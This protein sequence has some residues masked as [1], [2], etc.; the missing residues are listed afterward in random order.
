M[1]RREASVVVRLVL[2]DAIVATVVAPVTPSFPGKV[3]AE[4]G[5]ARFIPTAT[6]DGRMTSPLVGLFGKKN[7]VLPMRPTPDSPAPV[8]LIALLATPGQF[9]PVAG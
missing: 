7:S 9:D 8:V 5:L 2:S 4:L 1:V 3:P 6:H